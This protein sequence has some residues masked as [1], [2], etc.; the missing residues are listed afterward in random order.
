MSK[1]K[2]KSEVEHLRGLVREMKSQL[3]NVK[4]RNKRSEKRIKGYQQLVDAS[5]EEVNEEIFVEK[6]TR[7][8]ECNAYVDIIDL[9]IKDLWMCD[10]CGARGTFKKK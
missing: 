1:S 5:Q 9:Q 8:P 4:K 3:R 7:C 6:K 2:S 10:A